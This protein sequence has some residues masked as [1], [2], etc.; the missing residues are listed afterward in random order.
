MHDLRGTIRF[1]PSIKLQQP[2]MVLIVFLTYQPSCRMRYQNLSL[3]L[4]LLVLKENQG[5]HFA[6]RPFLYE[7]LSKYCVFSY[8]PVY[9]KYFNCKCNASKILA[10]VVILKFE[11]K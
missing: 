8:V 6:Q 11:I 3:P 5:P 10:L 4:S 9:A 7:Y 2:V 1:C